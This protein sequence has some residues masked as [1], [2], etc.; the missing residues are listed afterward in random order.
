MTI[1]QTKSAKNFVCGPSL[2]WLAG[3][4]QE[5]TDGFISFLGLVSLKPKHIIRVYQLTN[6]RQSI[7][8]MKF[9]GLHLIFFSTV[10]TL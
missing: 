9:E 4:R 6:Q 1:D 2:G 3:R 7:L 10:E 8:G 5:N